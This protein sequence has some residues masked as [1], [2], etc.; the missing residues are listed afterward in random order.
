MRQWDSGRKAVRS[1]LVS[2]ASHSH[3]EA[4]QDGTEVIAGETQVLFE[5]GETSICHTALSWRLR[6][7][8]GCTYCRCWRDR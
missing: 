4:G 3:V 1:F 7:E 5:A 6:V 8:N 2:G